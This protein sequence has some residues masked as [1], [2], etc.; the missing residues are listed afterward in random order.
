MPVL[1]PERGNGDRLCFQDLLTALD[2]LAARKPAQCKKTGGEQ[3][4]GEPEI[5]KDADK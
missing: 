3:G 1:L 4:S 5:Q 2:D